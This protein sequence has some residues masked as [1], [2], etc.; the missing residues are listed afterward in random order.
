ME[1]RNVIWCCIVVCAL[2]CAGCKWVEFWSYGLRV[3]VGFWRLSGFGVGFCVSGFGFM[4][5]SLV[6]S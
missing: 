6:L 5:C 1:N 3:R 4:G 2:F